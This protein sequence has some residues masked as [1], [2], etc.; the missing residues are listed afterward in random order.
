MVTLLPNTLT[1]AEPLQQ[2][3]EREAG[4]IGLHLNADNIELMC[5][6]KEATSPH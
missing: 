5:L 1:Q 6:I 2:N 3:L 4:G